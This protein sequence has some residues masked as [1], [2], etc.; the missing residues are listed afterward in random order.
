V[1]E[2]RLEESA[3]AAARDAAPAADDAG[4]ATAP[5]AAADS[6]PL[7]RLRRPAVALVTGAWLPLLA[8]A[9]AIVL[10]LAS[11][12]IS[13][14]EPEVVAL[15]P[16]VVRIVG[17]RQSGA[18]YVYLQPAFVSTGAN[19]RVEVV[20][21]MTLTARPAD[22]SEP[23]E[24][25][26]REEVALVTDANGQLSYRHEGDAVPL[27]VGPRSAAAPLALFQAPP[28]WFFEEG[29]YQF[30]LEADR[31]VAAAPLTASFEVTLNAA[32]MAV[33]GATG[34]EQFLA[35]AIDDDS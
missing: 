7:R 11:I 35:F 30:T 4:Y 5:A 2:A 13:T 18:S 28:G 23:A 10:S 20:R 25:Q 1:P 8:S 34:P 22:G 9:L 19:D 24:L 6:T 16:D 17:G 15:L 29:T 33:L 27:L 12:Y 26:W 3:T 32:D 21:D 14:R 31:V